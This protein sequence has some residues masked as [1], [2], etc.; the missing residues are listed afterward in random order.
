[1]SYR[2]LTNDQAKQVIDAEQLFHALRDAERAARAYSGGMHWKKIGDRQ[3]L[4]KSEGRNG[5]AKSLGVRSEDTEAK[6]AAFDQAKTRTA[7]LAKG[8]RERMAI[9]ARVNAALRVGSVPNP[10]ADICAELDRANVLGTNVM[11]IGTNS[12]HVY[13][14]MAGVRFSSDIMS[15]VD[16]D[17]LWNHKTKLSLASDAEFQEKALIEI[18]QRADK[19][20]ALSSSMRH[21]AISASGYMVDLVRQ[22]PN[23][24]WAN[25]P[26][27]FFVAENGEAADLVATDIW[28]MKWL[29]GAPRVTQPVIAVN[30]RVVNMTAPDPRAYA[31]FKLWLS[32]AEDREPEKKERDLA[33][34]RAVIALVEDR[35]PH[36]AANW[37][38]LHSFPA[39]V[40]EE[41][42]VEV[43]RMRG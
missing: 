11:V 18:L 10:V 35:L 29:L 41:T 3:Y 16:L 27:S 34:A 36:L 23:P 5:K 40:V 17:L 43:E 32:K 13:E 15:T 39:E 2:L 20:F 7:E 12:M 37:P 28:N 33:Q 8:L 21:R 26:D 42:L 31:M 1:M 24:P 22:M 6:L 9:Q 4:Y 30:G 14:A 25:E 38:S 19:S